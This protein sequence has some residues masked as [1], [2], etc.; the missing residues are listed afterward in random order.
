MISAQ[1]AT[2]TASLPQCTVGQLVMHALSAA[3]TKFASTTAW[4]PRLPQWRLSGTTRQM[5]A[6]LT[7]WWHRAASLHGGTVMPVATGGVP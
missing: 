5:M 6:L 2:C 3:D 7:V 1:M 4:L